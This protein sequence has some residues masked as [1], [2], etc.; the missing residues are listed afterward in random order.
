MAYRSGTLDDMAVI[1]RRT[2]RMKRAAREA[3][4]PT[5][6]QV[7]SNK[8]KLA[9]HDEAIAAAKDSA[10]TA[11]GLASALTFPGQIVFS[12]ANSPPEGWELAFVWSSPG[13]EVYA[14]KKSKKEEEA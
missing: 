2:Q 7:N 14:F 4:K 5:G 6:S 10:D 9:E 3:N 13:G 12:A 8:E 1:R 11:S